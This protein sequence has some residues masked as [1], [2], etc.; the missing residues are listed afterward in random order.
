MYKADFYKKILIFLRKMLMIDK[1]NKTKESL[2]KKHKLS[3]YYFV[4]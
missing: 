1:H 3:V 4:Y 2:L